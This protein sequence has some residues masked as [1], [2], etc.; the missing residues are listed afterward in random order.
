MAR[1]L[2][3][4]VFVIMPFGRVEG[5][6]RDQGQL[7]A[8]FRNHLKRPI[9]AAVDLEH[10]YS[11]TRSGEAFSI[12]RDIIRAMCT[13]DVVIADLSGTFPNP[14]VMYELGVRL[15]VSEKPV[16]LI[17]EDLPE[18]PNPFDVFAYYT[19]SYDP[20]DYAPLEE[21]LLGKLARLETGE[22]VFDNEVL[23]LIADEVALVTPDPTSIPPDRQRELVLEGVR[24]LGNIVETAYG[25]HGLGL[26]GRFD[27]GAA[28][29]VMRGN[30]LG[31]H[32][33]SDNPFEQEGIQLLA[34]SGEDMAAE[35]NDGS[36][37]AMIMARAMIDT[38]AGIHPLVE[39]PSEVAAAIR[40]ASD[41]IQDLLLQQAKTDM[42]GHWSDLAATAAKA[43]RL[44]VDMDEVLAAASPNGVVTVEEW[45][46]EQTVIDIED[47][48][49]FDRGALHEDF[50]IDANGT[51]SVLRG[52]A[53]LLCAE[54]IHSMIE[55]LPILE[56]VAQSGR[57]VLLVA[58]KVEGEALATLRVNVE[59]RS[60]HCVP[61]VAPGHGDGRTEMLHDLAVLTGGTVITA[62]RGLRLESTV[63]S[64]LGSAELIT[65][66][67]DWTR[68]TDGGGEPSAIE[69]QIGRLKDRLNEEPA[70]Y[71][72]QKLLER[73]AFLA[74]Q[75]ITI[76]V[77][78]ESSK[79]RSTERRMISEGLAACNAA[80]ARG[81][82]SGSASHLAQL[83]ASVPLDLAA[84]GAD[85]AREIIAAGLE[86]PL[87]VLARNAG[88]D[89]AEVV[90]KVRKN[91]TY[92]ARERACEDADTT[93]I[94][95]SVA[96]PI[97]AAAIA[98]E[99][100]GRFL[101]A[102]SWH[103]QKMAKNRFSDTS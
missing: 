69:E 103:P 34:S 93:R 13:A 40:H 29:L 84:P 57:P 4:S 51:R 22:E 1:K 31:R 91:G 54:P 63:L 12:T 68:I 7:T 79:T 88:D 17:K 28:E 70:E 5:G 90:E 97:R 11:V 59:R 8:F 41:R 85:H 98:G 9:E 37:L 30:A 71:A 101:L 46:G 96:V 66:A 49:R 83:A 47:G 77:G 50:L 78:G 42:E 24:L 87:R 26:H 36:K 65:I 19:K 44:P 89:E 58:P 18:T 86:A 73:I 100:V 92:N 56:K 72:R 60:L 80:A 33:A 10:R 3:R 74:G 39:A 99:V 43:L 2:T 45:E 55:I 67:R 75:H 23:R 52:A 14:N 21:H 76:K 38:A 64:D 6:L 62:G 95:D 20:L 53:V 61:V 25:P 16:I 94:T 82:I 15:A 27:A 32:T 102:G 81:W 48:Y 35:L